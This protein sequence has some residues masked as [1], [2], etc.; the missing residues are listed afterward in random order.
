MIVFDCFPYWRERWAV[1]ARLRLWSTLAPDVEYMPVAFLGDRTHRGNPLPPDLPP[2]PEGVGRIH[3][4]LDAEG[5]WGREEQQ[6][7]AVTR[8]AEHLEPDDLILLTDADEIVDPRALPLILSATE[9][10]PVKLSMPLYMCGL[11]WRNVH[12]WRHPAACRAK[13]LPPAPSKNLRL[14]FGLPAVTDSGWHLTYLGSDEDIDAKLSAFAHA[15][16]DTAEDRAELARI[17]EHGDAE[18]VDDPLGD[19]LASILAEVLP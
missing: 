16:H 13:D 4:T 11:R 7:D 14:N 8:L 19:P 3:V 2:L 18:R 15:E 10:G 9:R 17:R 1:D 12:P 6:R 5:D